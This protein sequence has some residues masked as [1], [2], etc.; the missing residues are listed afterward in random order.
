MRKKWNYIVPLVLLLIW[1]FLDMTGL[2]WGNHC[3]VA[4]SYKEDFL[5]FIIYLVAFI[6]FLVKE[7]IGKWIML[8]W[9]SMWFITQFLNHEWYTIFHGGF[10]GTAEG[11]MEYFSNTIKWLHI[12]GRYVPDLYHTV[13]HL[14]LLIAICSTCVYIIRTRKR[15]KSIDRF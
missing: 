8:I 1:F 9:L 6:L 2:Y 10:M 4:K 3:L 15:I 11:K 12:E 5:F 7:T 14:L 13:L